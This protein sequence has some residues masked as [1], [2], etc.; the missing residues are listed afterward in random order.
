[1]VDQ[2]TSAA[3]G[4]KH[5]EDSP[6]TPFL[7]RVAAFTLGGM[8][9]DGYI[10]GHIGIALALAAP[11]LGLGGLWLGLLAASTLFGI[12]I[13]APLAGRLADRFGRR[14]L[15][16]WD[17]AL[18]AVLALAHLLVNDPATLLAIRTVMGV[19]I[20]AEYA[21]GASVLAEFAPRRQR[22]TLLACLNGAWIVGFVAGFASAYGMRAAGLSWHMIFASAAVPA[23][24]V[25]LVRWGSPESPRWLVEQGRD[26]EA[27]QVV[28]K[29]Y[30]PEY[31]ISGLSGSATTEQEQAT[32]GTL[33]S[34]RYW[35]RTVFAG[36][37]WAFQVMPLFALTIFLPQVFSAL[38]VE[39]EF[40]GEMFVN[41]MLLV[42]AVAG[43]IAVRLLTRRGLVIWSFAIVAAVLLVMSAAE[44]LP[45]WAG[46][47][48]FAVF[49]L[50]AS[51]ASNLEYVYP[52]EIFPT[53]V[54]ATGMGVA[55]AM[56]RVGA[57]IS[58]FLLPITLEG[59]GN[60]PTMIILAGIAG[61]GVVISVLWAPETKGK[62]LSEAAEIGDAR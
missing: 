6:M 32:F 34:Q 27:K 8:F 22:G 10:L 46:L 2:L 39:S 11:L 53:E 48:A 56:S 54:R 59:L 47:G 19:L 15:L 62:L 52:S 17:F 3:S 43:V 12:L 61:L 5:I 4:N 18:F 20:G 14:R 42:G 7:V 16:A 38:G 26:T 40:G 28:H 25:F 60:A 35:R 24:I 21:I 50:V 30:G 44:A 9:T 33:F 13:G 37:F 51:A 29:F 49:V 36:G 57:V 41:G 45:Q 23:A 1:M 55:A 31:G 58:T